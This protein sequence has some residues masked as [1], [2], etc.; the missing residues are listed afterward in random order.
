MSISGWFGGSSVPPSGAET[1]PRSLADERQAMRLRHQRLQRRRAAGFWGYRIAL[2]VLG[3]CVGALLGALAITHPAVVAGALFAPALIFWMVKR[4]E[5][6][7][8]ALGLL[9]SPLVPAAFTARSVIVYPVE[10]ALIV[11][12]GAVI[13]LAAF[14]VRTFVWPSLRVI[15]P[16]LGLITLAI[17]STI[18][19]QVTW[20]PEAPHRLNSTPILF[21]ELLGI[22]MYCVPL[23]VILVTTACLSQRAQWIVALENMFL[24]VSAL[25]AA[26]VCVKFKQIGADVYLFR[27]TE[28][29]I[30]YMPL[31]ALA[32]F[33]GLGAMLAYARALY[34]PRWRVRLAYLTLM[35]LCLVAVYITLE[36]SRLLYTLVGLAV[37][38]LV[39]SR[40]LFVVMVAASL[41]LIPVAL[42]VINRLAQGKAAGDLN[43][44]TI[45]Q[46]MLRV[47]LKRPLLGVGPGDVWPYDQVYT[48]L[49]IALR[50]LNTTG[51]GVAHNG[52]LQTLAEVG[53]LGVVCYYAFAV[54]I[55]A[56]AARLFRRS[57]APERRADRI[58]AITC[59]GLLFGS[60][61]ADPISGIFFLPPAQIGGFNMLAR[62]IP[63]WIMFGCLIYKD[64]VWRMETRT[65][66]QMEARQA[67]PAATSVA[68][69]FTRGR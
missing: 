4:L 62:V 11:L 22:A 65:A 66:A 34:T 33:I 43:R 15:W 24:V 7:L 32:Q 59:L 50:N 17:L 2:V 54:I 37:I 64:Q 30:F 13:T 27:Y 39:F 1:P 3:G 12:L 67:A 36:K 18:M 44:L 31:A 20:D 57:R 29:T 19:I 40:R 69:P 10:L 38:T 21:S 42:A 53:P 61:V 41:P 46:D 55:M 68:A 28:S 52:V 49:P 9:A 56:L 35:L 48:H 14:R 51:L 16:Q 58:L 23:T 60:L 26:L 63:T 47:W 8:V 6:G 25:A 45:W 5:V